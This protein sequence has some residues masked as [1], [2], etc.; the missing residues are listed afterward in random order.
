MRDQT[1]AVVLRVGA[2]RLTELHLEAPPD[3][4]TAVE[5]TVIPVTDDLQ[6]ERKRDARASKE[7]GR[8]TVRFEQPIELSAGEELQVVLRW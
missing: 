1:N 6:S 7:G 4:I 2:L 8:W 3:E 5:V